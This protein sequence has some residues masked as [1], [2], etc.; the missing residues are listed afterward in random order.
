MSFLQITYKCKIVRVSH[1]LL[2]GKEP[3]TVTGRCLFQTGND[4]KFLCREVGKL[5]LS[6]E[7]CIDYGTVQDCCGNLASGSATIKEMKS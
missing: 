2:P 3:V 1:L 4:Q 7:Y 5:L 6:P